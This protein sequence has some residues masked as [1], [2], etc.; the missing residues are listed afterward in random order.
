MNLKTHFFWNSAWLIF[1]VVLGFNIMIEK[2]H[3]PIM[4]N[5]V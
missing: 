5:K 3:S 2:D 1:R 4:R